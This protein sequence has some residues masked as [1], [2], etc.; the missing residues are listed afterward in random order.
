[1]KFPIKQEDNLFTMCIVQMLFRARKIQST[2]T[3]FSLKA[4]K[5]NIELYFTQESSFSLCDTDSEKKT[6]L[7]CL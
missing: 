5:S 3:C 4:L 7:F 1:M 6:Q 2:K